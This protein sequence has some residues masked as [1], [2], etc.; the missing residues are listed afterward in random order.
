MSNNWICYSFILSFSVSSVFSLT[1]RR[2]EFSSLLKSLSHVFM[3]SSDERVLRNS[4]V[5]LTHFAEGDHSRLDDVR[6]ELKNIVENLKKK[7]LDHLPKPFLRTQHISEGGV[8]DDSSDETSE[9]SKY[10]KEKKE[11]DSQFSLT[12]A[13]KKLSILS[14]RC[15]VST[16]LGDENN[17]ELISALSEGIKQRLSFFREMI[18]ND[19]EGKPNMITFKTFT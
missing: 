16:Y 2:Q 6:A 5:S 3:H 1:Q 8:P 11:G 17:F 18:S 7:V 9:S 12:L 10:N 19:A 15:N 4:A 14:K 13:V